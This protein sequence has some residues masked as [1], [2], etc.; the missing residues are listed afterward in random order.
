[1]GLQGHADRSILSLFQWSTFSFLLQLYY[2]KSIV[3]T[4][5]KTI[6]PKSGS[7]AT[8]LTDG[9]SSLIPRHAE[10]F[11][12]LCILTWGKVHYLLR[13]YRKGGAEPLLSISFL[14]S[15]SCYQTSQGSYISLHFTP[16]LKLPVHLSEE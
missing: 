9:G 6:Q 4:S 10:E 12:Q 5:Y 2:F 11:L 13:L 15:N 1:M 8:V 3:N 16:G 7:Q 14:K